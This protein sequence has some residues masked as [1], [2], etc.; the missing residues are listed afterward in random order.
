MEIRKGENLIEHRDEIMSRPARTWFQTEKEKKA[1]QGEYFRVHLFPSSNSFAD[2]SCRV[3]LSYPDA[4]KGAYVSGFEAAAAALKGKGKSELEEKKVSCSSSLSLYLFPSSA[5]SSR[6]RT[7]KLTRRSLLF[8]SQPK[9]DKY[10]GLS[11]RLKRRKMAAEEDAEVGDTKSIS[12]SIRS[13][14]K[15]SRPTKITEAEAKPAGKASR[16]GGKPVGEKAKKIKIGKGAFDTEVSFCVSLFGSIRLVSDGIGPEEEEKKENE[17]RSLTVSVVFAFSF[18]SERRARLLEERELELEGRMAL[19]WVGRG[20]PRLLL[21][22]ELRVE[23]S[24]R[25]RE[26]RDKAILY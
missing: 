24:P 5:T 7:L 2:S 21:R 8:L 18:S 13:A 23:E 26:G 19:G 4:S 3:R 20:S 9:R 17:I 6:S 1:S 16:K 14:K 25:G 12:A 15:S 22:V 11:R 10:D